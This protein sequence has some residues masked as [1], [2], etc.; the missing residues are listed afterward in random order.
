ML[1]SS[2]YLVT[3]PVN[4]KLTNTKQYEK[5]FRGSSCLEAGDL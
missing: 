5:C 2:R 4:R 1:S 3:L